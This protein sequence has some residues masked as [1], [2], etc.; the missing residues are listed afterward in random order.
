MHAFTLPHVF[1]PGLATLSTTSQTPACLFLQPFI[2]APYWK[3][4]YHIL[5]FVAAAAL[6]ETEGLVADISLYCLCLC[7]VF[8]LVFAAAAVSSET[9][10][11]VAK[12]GVLCFCLSLRLVFVAAAVLSDTEG[13]VVED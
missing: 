2:E 9:K 3:G 11:L 7:L 6:S 12:I 13:L 8:V 5:V 4:Q 10:S 1:I